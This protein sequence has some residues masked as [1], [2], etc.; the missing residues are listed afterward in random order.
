MTVKTHVLSL[1][2][3]LHFCN[4]VS[5]HEL[6]ADDILT[7]AWG[8]HQV[9]ELV[10]ELHTA[11]MV[12]RC[13]F[14][15]LVPQNQCYTLGTCLRI[16]W[17][18]KHLKHYKL[19]QNRSTLKK[20]VCSAMCF[21]IPWVSGG[22][23]ITATRPWLGLM[24]WTGSELQPDAALSAVT[25]ATDWVSPTR[26]MSKEIATPWRL[27]SEARQQASIR[28]WSHTGKQTWSLSGMN[29]GNG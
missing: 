1:S 17:S 19:Q 27:K 10:E 20:F 24:G 26:S 11:L 5:V 8:R 9:V 25:M 29:K 23:M 12:L 6:L 13:S 3:Y 7:D 14:T 22:L 2:V 15:Q 28:V 4:L 21:R 16:I 18:Q